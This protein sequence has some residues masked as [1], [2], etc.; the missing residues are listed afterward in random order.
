MGLVILRGCKLNSR[1][2]LLI[3]SLQINVLEWFWGPSGSSV[4]R[5]GQLGCAWGTLRCGSRNLAA[6]MPVG[7]AWSLKAIWGVGGSLKLFLSCCVTAVVLDTAGF[8][9]TPCSGTSLPLFC[10]KLCTQRCLILGMGWL[11]LEM[12]WRNG[13]CPVADVDKPKGS[14]C[15]RV[16]QSVLWDLILLL[17]FSHLHWLFYSISLQLQQ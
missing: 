1:E 10:K 3:S 2:P 6:L 16:S 15:P 5:T 8:A 17:C 9:V 7:L 14:G 4:G 12:F 11:W 13:F